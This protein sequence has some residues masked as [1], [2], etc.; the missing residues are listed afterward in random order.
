MEQLTVGGLSIDVVRKEIKN[1]H[2]AV[3]PPEGR[4]RLAAPKR[5]DSE[6]VRLFAISKLDWLRKHVKSFQD[7]KR[8]S[9]RRFI[10]GEDH[11]V[12]GRR[13][14]LEVKEHNAPPKIELG[15]KRMKMLV[16]PNTPVEK[17]EELLKEWYRA[18]LKAQLPEIIA[19]WQA[20]VGVK[21]A[22]YGVKRMRT[23]W[24]S[25]S[26]DSK[27]IWINLELAKKP[28]ICLEYIVVHE[29]VHLL[30]RNHNDRFIAHMNRFMPN[31]RLHRE[32]LN[33]LPVAHVDWGY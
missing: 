4:I 23:K 22:S 29:L 7:Q 31:W 20:I 27:Q 5:T 3:Y 24:G 32:E 13:Y 17:R 26:V 2:L 1:M 33:R 12:Q 28:T 15:A 16:R 30:E 6:V 18:R 19:K 14:Q 10:S 8:E 11:Y 9:E 21:C 25:C